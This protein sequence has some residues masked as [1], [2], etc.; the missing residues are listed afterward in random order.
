MTFALIVEYG[1]RCVEYHTAAGSDRAAAAASRSGSLSSHS[2]HDELASMAPATTVDD[3]L[4]VFEVVP[5]Q[6][7]H[8]IN[9]KLGCWKAHPSFR[10]TDLES[11]RGL[12]F[13]PPHFRVQQVNS[14]ST[15]AAVVFASDVPEP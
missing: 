8:Q 15:A 5:G 6:P 1:R 11:A 12:E 14:E 7:G 13:R 9:R 10:K 2:S 4:D 3:P